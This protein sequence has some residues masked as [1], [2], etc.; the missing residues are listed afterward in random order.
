[1]LFCLSCN[2]ERTYDDNWGDLPIFRGNMVFTTNVSSRAHLAEDMLN[3]NFGVIGFKYSPTSSW[4]GAKTITE[5]GDFFYNVKV[6]CGANGACTYNTVVDTNGNNGSD[7]LNDKQWENNL[8]SFFAYY[9]YNGAGIISLSDKSVVD[10]PTLTYEYPWLDSTDNISVYDSNSSIVDLMTAE[11][12]DVNGSGDGRVRLDFQHRLFAFEILANN[13]NESTF[14]YLVDENGDYI[15]DADGNKQFELDANNE[16]IV[17][18]SAAQKITALTLTLEGLQNK[19]MTIPLSML[20]DEENNK[21]KYTT[22]TVGTRTFKISDDPLTIPA[23]NE[24]IERT[25]NGKTEITGGGVATS[26]SKYGSTN[27]GYLFLIP[28]QGSSAGIHG[29]IKWAELDAFV[30]DGGEVNNEF[31]STIT[32]KPGTLYQIYINFVGSG[33]T[34]ALIEAGTWDTLPV[35]PEYRFE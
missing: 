17:D 24:K 6:E 11:A 9:P 4:G 34:I 22:G 13:Y 30:A 29:T 26:I 3:K 18:V 7:K 12:I 20:N 1:M 27:G 21:I 8:Y 2:S 31:T 35:D 10:T 32:F 28:Q 14:K 25:F 5:P 16:K 19:S 15:L 33:I 23:Y